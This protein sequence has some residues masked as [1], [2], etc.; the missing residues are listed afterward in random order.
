MYMQC[1]FAGSRLQGVLRVVQGT[2]LQ[3]CFG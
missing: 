1:E 3:V 2:R